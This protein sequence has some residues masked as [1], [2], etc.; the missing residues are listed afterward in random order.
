MS[1]DISDEREAIAREKIKALYG[2]SGGEYGPTLFV[3]HH[4]NQIEAAYWLRIMGVEQPRAEQILN[5]LVLVDSWSSEGD[6][7]ANTLD[8]GLPG[9]VSNY[10]LSVRFSDDDQV[11]DVSM[12]S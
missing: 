5:A 9:N 6:N 7:V 12:E 3:Q 10:L 4:L 2:V 8:F 11:I 1:A